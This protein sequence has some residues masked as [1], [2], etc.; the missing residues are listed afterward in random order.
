VTRWAVLTGEY[1]PQPGGV[2]DY[3]RLVAA[4]LAAAGDAVTVYTSPHPGP[5]PRDTPVSLRRLPDHFG[6]RGLLALD[7]ALSARPRPDRVLVQYVAHAFGWKGMNLPFAAWVAAR[8]ARVAPVW[9]MFHEVMYPVEPGQRLRHAVLGRVTRAMA[10]LLARSADRV[11]VSIPAWCV[12]LRRICRAARPAEW[13]PIPSNVPD[14]ADPAAVAAVRARLGPGATVVGHFGTFGAMN[15]DLIGPPLAD[16]LRR[17]A[18]RVALLVGRNAPAYR[19]RFVAE[20]PDLTDRV[21]AT[22]DLSAAAVAVHLAACDLLL[23]PYP[24]GASTRRTSLMSGLALGVPTATNAGILSEP[25]WAECA[26]VAVAPSAEPAALVAAAEGLLALPPEERAARGRAAA[27]WYRARFAVEHTV[28]RL[29]AA[30]SP[31]LAGG[32]FFLTPGKPG[33]I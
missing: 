15:A 16:L 22:G 31:R 30:Y 28:A 12:L 24:D 18:G 29:R 11:F 7:R 6:P 13:L 32:S 25:I 20:R 21:T 10:R 27:A 23:Q 26:G 2:S 4:G 19:E 3:T 17:P 9:V 1:P 5:Q 33:A 8:A 14:A